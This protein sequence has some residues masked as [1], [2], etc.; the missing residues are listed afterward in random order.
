MIESHPVRVHEN[1]SEAIGNTPLIRLTRFGAQLQHNLL[2][3]CEFMNPGGSV[4][5]RIALRMIDDAERSGHLQPGGTIVE[6]TA[7]NTG[8]GLALIAALR[9]YKLITVMSAK[10]STDKIE[11]LK[12]LGAE[13]VI[14]PAG[15]S[16]DDPEHFVNQAMQIAKSTGGWLADQFNNKSNVDAHY[17]TTGP[18]IWQQ[19]NGKVDVLVAGVGTGGTLTGAGSYLK[20][21]NPS[22]RIVLADP[23]GSML[24]DLVRRGSASNSAPY[25]VE[26][27]GQDFIPGNLD[28]DIIDEAIQVSDGESVATAKRLLA[29]EG[30]FV[31]SSSGCIAHAAEKFAAS[32]PG[33][34]LNIVV[35]LPD[36]GRGYV[37][38]VYNAD[39]LAGKCL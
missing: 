3:K 19:T 37:S 18:E 5:D 22:L 35:I 12:A 29:T 36:S 30:M 10:V 9:G 16:I 1:I 38:T 15:K 8:V 33:H 26:G 25:I 28:R 24:A 6:A 31:G 2:A 17:T 34:G 14:T 21:R 23:V 11:F 32:L 27:I 20:E 13:T 4:K 39:W 7:G